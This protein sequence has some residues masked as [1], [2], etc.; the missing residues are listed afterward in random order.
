MVNF[1]VS[2]GTTS[3]TL[4]N[5]VRMVWLYACGKHTHSVC[6]IQSSDAQ[7]RTHS[8][9]DVY[10]NK[11][12]VLCKCPHH[13]FPQGSDGFDFSL[14]LP[15]TPLSHTHTP[16]TLNHYAPHTELW[17]TSV[18]HIFNLARTASISTK[19][20]CD[21]FCVCIILCMIII[22]CV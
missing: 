12:Q 15:G 14:W 16:H 10:I 11:C 6:R 7:F 3:V 5:G 17:T 1:V 19:L 9:K 21:D 18:Q 13:R 4:G 22:L 20:L 2:V 8:P